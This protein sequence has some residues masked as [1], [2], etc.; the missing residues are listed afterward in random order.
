[1]DVYKFTMAR[2]EGDL[3]VNEYDKAYCRERRTILGGNGADRVLK[4][5]TVIGAVAIAG[6][7][8]AAAK[9]ANASAANGV[10]AG[11]TVAAGTKPGIFTATCIGAVANGG[12]FIFEDPTGIELGEIV[13]GVAFNLGGISATIADGATDWA[14][15]DQV[16]YTVTA[17]AAGT[18]ANGAFKYVQVSAA[19]NDGSQNAAAILIH[20]TTAPNGVDTLASTWERGPMIV[21]AEELIWPAGANNAQIAAWTAQLVAKGILVR[22][23]G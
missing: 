13:V 23:S 22:T 3:V 12:K 16:L 15:G 4:A 1:M 9:A 11:A 5:F 14:E 8:V 10:I 20:D 18:D 6:L 19:A 21:R 17:T 2:R 7:S